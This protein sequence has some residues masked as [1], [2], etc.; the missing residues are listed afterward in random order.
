M[1]IPTPD[2]LALATRY[3]AQALRARDTAARTS[4]PYAKGLTDAYVEVV[5]DLRAL[6]GVVDPTP[7]D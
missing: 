6:A 7:E 5:A 3:S 4:G 2:L 1:P